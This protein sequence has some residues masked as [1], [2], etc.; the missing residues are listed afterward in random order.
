MQAFMPGA[1]PPDVSTAI[2][3]TVY[4]IRDYFVAIINKKPR[5]CGV[6][7][8]VIYLGKISY[9]S[10]CNQ[11]QRSRCGFQWQLNLGF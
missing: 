2:F 5:E 11:T 3:F 1:S 10:S 7:A 8:K 9:Q 6:F 4:K